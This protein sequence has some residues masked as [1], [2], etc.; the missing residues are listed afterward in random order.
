MNVTAAM[1]LVPMGG[2]KDAPLESGALD[3]LALVQSLAQAPAPPRS[4][5]DAQARRSEFS[6]YRKRLAETMPLVRDVVKTM[7]KND[8]ANEQARVEAQEALEEETSSFVNTLTKEAASMAFKLVR[9]LVTGGTRILVAAVGTTLELIGGAVAFLVANPAV[10]IAVGVVALGFAGYYYYKS[11]TGEGAQDNKP[12]PHTL[13]PAAPAPAPAQPQPKVSAPAPTSSAPAAPKAAA[14]TTSAPAPVAQPAAAAPAP[15]TPSAGAAAG[16]KTVQKAAGNA[17]KTK[18]SEEVTNA[19]I[20]A[21][22]VVGVPV[23]LLTALAGVESSFGT[24]TVAATSSARG[25]FQFIKGTWAMM[26]KRYGARFGVPADADPNNHQW[27]AILAA[28]MIK[29]EGYPAVAKI[30]SQPSITDVYLTHFLGAGGGASFL[31]GYIANPAAPASS[32]V[33]AAQARANASI[34]A[35]NGRDR[36]AQEVYDVFANKLQA[37]LNKASDSM[38][39]AVAKD[40]GAAATTAEAAPSQAT[41]AKPPAQAPASA[42][43]P[44]PG[45][46]ASQA[47]PKSYDYAKVGRNQQIVRMEN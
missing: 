46:S 3:L 22:K 7:F 31:R 34:F 8:A 10:A 27:S 33:G 39:A 23:S 4:I 44:T 13:Q 19:I 26:M 43:T 40:S 47:T 36:T 17:K 21:S 32:L 41:T 11:K 5:E 9:I 45:A 24:N 25:L 1:S 2:R 15:S 29:F 14:V 37:Q 42:S 30:V 35:S 20:N 18:I 28:A 16:R 6:S 12:A 38:D